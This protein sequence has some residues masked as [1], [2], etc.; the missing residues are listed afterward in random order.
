MEIDIVLNKLEWS[1]NW[2]F[3]KNI[4]K[5]HVNSWNP[6]R[7]FVGYENDFDGA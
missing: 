5:E 4:R 7:Y 6:G 2:D 1:T 3:R